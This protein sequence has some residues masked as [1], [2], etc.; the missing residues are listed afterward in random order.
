M[1]TGRRCLIMAR[2]RKVFTLGEVEKALDLSLARYRD[3]KYTFNKR[4]IA[5]RI[6]RLRQL[7][8]MADRHGV[9]D[10]H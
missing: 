4:L 8:K 9:I 3:P 6:K 1:H 10:L 2:Y 7:A 5:D